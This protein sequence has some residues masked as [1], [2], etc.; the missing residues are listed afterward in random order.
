MEDKKYNITRQDV[1]NEAY[2]KC[3][4]EMYA[5]SQPSANF[6]ELCEKYAGTNE[7]IFERYYLSQEEFNYILNKY[8]DA[9]GLH[10]KRKEFID[11]II[12][13]LQGEYSVDNY[14]GPHT[15]E[16]GYHPGY[17]SYKTE[18]PLKDYIGEDNANKVFEVLNERKNFYYTSLEETRFKSSIALGCSPNSNEDSVKEYWEKQGVDL[19]IDPRHNDYNFFWEEEN[20]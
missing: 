8:V 5:K 1:I 12:E 10:D 11:L 19:K 6:K 9:Y 13:N 15:D 7:H 14:V 17:R 2:D 20:L 16:Y 3:L 18:S 4:T